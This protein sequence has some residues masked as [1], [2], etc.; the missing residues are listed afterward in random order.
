MLK[1]KSKK[2]LF[3]ISLNDFIIDLDD[4]EL[5]QLYNEY[6]YSTNKL[7]L[8]NNI[9]LLKIDDIIDYIIN[10]SNSLTNNYIQLLIDEYENLNDD[11]ILY[12]SLKDVQK[13]LNC[14]KAECNN[15]L[16]FKNGV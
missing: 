5:M 6:C 4:I 3:K 10:T 14:Q 13:C 16:R 8:V 12:D 9:S 7:T 11:L 2:E 15:C 1:V